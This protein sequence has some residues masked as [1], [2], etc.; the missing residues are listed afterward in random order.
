[1]VGDVKH[2]VLNKTKLDL[3]NEKKAKFE[4]GYW[5]KLP[6]PGWDRN[7]TPAQRY[8][9]SLGGCGFGYQYLD[10]Y[11]Q[12]KKVDKQ[13]FYNKYNVFF[14]ECNKQAYKEV[15]KYAPI[16]AERSYRVDKTMDGIWD[17]DKWRKYE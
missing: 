9:G 3:L 12:V 17:S 4:A 15:L 5:G 13:Y 2:I 6:A 16:V 14:L 7:K 8:A 1:M 10:Y 11:D